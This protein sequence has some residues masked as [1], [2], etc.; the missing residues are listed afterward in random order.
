MLN[1]PESVEGP[2]V[3]GSRRRV[4][5]PELSLEKLSARRVEAAQVRHYSR[6]V[7]TQLRRGA[8]L[9]ECSLDPLSTTAS[10]KHLRTAERDLAE[11]PD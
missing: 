9:S 10:E 8:R 7:A 5:V 2:A 1:V 3:G 6:V 4:G 11:R